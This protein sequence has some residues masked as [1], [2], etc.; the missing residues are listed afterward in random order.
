VIIRVRLTNWK[1][2]DH[3]DIELA[4]GTTFLIAPNGIG[5]SSFMDAVSWALDPN[6][7]P[8][9]LRM[10]RLA[11][12]TSVTVDLR[13]GTT[14]VAITRT[15]TRGRGAT[16]IL[17]GT[18]SI[19]G[20]AY[21]VSAALEWL[22]AAWNT[23]P[24]FLYRSAF[25]SD[26]LLLEPEEPNLEQ[27]LVRLYGLDRLREA[28]NSA[29]AA[30]DQLELQARDA[31][32]A[33]RTTAD[34]I[35]V[36]ESEASELED[37]ATAA[38]G[39]A[40][41][42][43]EDA[44]RA[45]GAVREAEARVRALVAY[46]DW[47][48]KYMALA[49]EVE[50]LLGDLPSDVGL[51]DVL[52][53]AEQGAQAQIVRQAERRAALME[54]I[55]AVEGALDRLHAAGGDCPICRRPLDGDSRQHAEEAHQADRERAAAELSALEP[56]PDDVA[57]DIA[58]LR[59]RLHDLGAEPGVP[60]EPEQDLDALRAVA[61]TATETASAARQRADEARVRALRAR[62]RVSELRDGQNAPDPVDMYARAG[63]LTAGARALGRTIEEVLSRQLGPLSDEVNRRWEA[64]FPDRPGLQVTQRGRVL[65]TY[66]DA[67]D[68]LPFEAF[69]SGEKVIAK[70]LMRLS[71][72]GTT[73]IP[74]IWI[75][76]PLE[77]LDPTSRE[78]VAHTLAL[79]TADNGISQ[80]VV[81]TYEDQIA[82]RLEAEEEHPVNLRVLRSVG[83]RN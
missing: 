25:L 3:F 20:E 57:A 56:G 37:A 33:T 69:S 72:I 48:A 45:S 18:A 49:M 15:L 10:R 63:L 66:D 75:D 38:A 35:T 65:R 28:Q 43:A 11:A 22:A 51:E 70:I 19:G 41:N 46:E 12:T 78:Y 29:K 6:A 1:A 83:V 42:A 58:R 82:R 5:K 26:R 34:Q 79:L 7:K 32:K 27:H 13:V 76:E 9:H 52:R 14:D 8:D 53:S 74:F 71:T 77:H 59:R 47:H 68:P 21:E 30:A 67:G 36:A 16:P 23:D 17:G 80:I 4:S 54:R 60:A 40:A 62:D 39:A 55:A 50:G 44:A 61:A 73:A 31:K 64:L 81:T 2:Y 24:G